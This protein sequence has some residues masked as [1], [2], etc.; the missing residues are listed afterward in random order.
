MAAVAGGLADIAGAGGAGLGDCVAALAN[1]ELF[2][3]VKNFCNIR[4]TLVL[5]IA[6]HKVWEMLIR[7]SVRYT[8][9]SNAFCVVLSQVSLS[10][11]CNKL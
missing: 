11:F 7:M 6:M 2:S 9:S 10:D 1:P 5:E 8:K 4:H 3:L